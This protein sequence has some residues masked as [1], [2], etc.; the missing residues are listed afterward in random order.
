MKSTRITT[1]LFLLFSAGAID[2][3]SQTITVRDKTTREPLP[4]VI[5]QD[6][7]NN[8]VSTNV[9]GQA[10]LS[11]LNKLD[12]LTVYQL[13]YMPKKMM[14]N[15]DGSAPVLE[16][17]SRTVNLDEVVLSVNRTEESK[18]NVPYNV[19][20]IRQKD[21][22]FIN[23]PTSGDLLQNTGMVSLQ[24]SQA[25]GG[26]PIIR[27]FEANKVLLV[28]DGVR[29]N[30]AIYRGGHLQDIMTVDP[31]MIERTEV[32][33]GPSSTVYG[34]DALGGV[35][36]FYTKNP[37]F[38]TDDKLLVKAN[39][40]LRYASAT[41]ER[42][43]HLDVNLG[44]K[45]FAS[46]TSVTH[47]DFGDLL[48]GATKLTGYSSSWDRRYY[49]ER[50]NDRDTMRT[51]ANDNLQ[52]G[53]AY[54]QTDLMQR[55]SLKTGTHLV[56]QL[57]FQYSTS[58]FLPRYD[59]LNGDYAGGNLRWAEN[60][61]GPQ[62][63][64]MAAY[65][66]NSNAKTRLSDNVRV[67]LAYQD[68]DQDRITR[69]FQN[70][71]RKVQMEDVTVLSVN[72]DVLKQINPKHGLR[73]GLEVTHNTV[74]STAHNKNIVSNV[75]T[76]A[77]TRYAG[78]GS[79]MSSMAAYLSHAW[80]VNDAFVITD[81]LRYT[82]TSLSAKF[83]DTTFFKFPFSTAK[84]NNQA[85]TGSLGFTWRAENDYKLSL[86]ANTGFRTPNVD[87]LSKVFESAGSVVVVP[88]PELKPEYTYNFE[89]SL[90]KVFESRYKFDLTGF[91]T[92]L[93]NAIVVKD[94]KLG[95]RDSAMYNGTM[96]RVRAAQ[97]VDQ[98]YIYGVSAGIQFDFNEN[99]S[100]KSVL[101][102]T[103]GRYIDTRN[104]TVLPL[105]HIPP[106]F[107]QTSLLYKNRNLDGEFF[108]RYNGKK[109]LGSYSPSGEDNL[110]YATANGMPGWFTL[111]V[112]AGFNFTKNI[113]LNVACENITDNRYRVF[114]SGINAPGR[115][116][117][118]SLR[119]KM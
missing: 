35:V 91:Y 98:A 117:I 1:I 118:I 79:S 62:Q 17:T 3:Y 16:L 78:G 30:N 55:F 24:K 44:W 104:D 84:Q 102:Y 85:V 56:H 70:P 10:D 53:S 19:E 22:E 101:N 15:P 65:T 57:N 38:S 28:I 108:V 49:V 89:I 60:G 4:D 66:L 39:A 76:P 21:I 77:D 43:G 11:G 33:F 18:I 41:Q 14:V 6:K 109:A 107:G 83:T 100:F 110:P 95:G 34:S 9:K 29:M 7:G 37:S 97:N 2:T 87:D 69:R 5:I 42:T 32:V 80:N 27:G 26:S 59:R 94:F 81:G 61:Y 105:D 88:N 68:I 8:R 99:V 74:T 112:R 46:L 93:T 111:N 52:K 106:V 114:A 47:S 96:S 50:I 71:N 86:L 72:A 67:I 48:S 119:Y 25:G 36:H 116:F 115:N 31:N 82:K 45:K 40:M 103:Y 92:N 20:V 58:S 54:S 113:R 73:Y 23:P 64:L 13:G 63:R 12:S 75:E 90:S 51:N